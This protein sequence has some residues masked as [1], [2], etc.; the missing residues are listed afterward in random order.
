V[1]QWRQGG[2]T[3]DAPGRT[4]PRG[5]GEEE[6]DGSSSA[7]SDRRQRNSE[8]GAGGCSAEQS[9]ELVCAAQ[10]TPGKVAAAFGYTEWR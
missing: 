4:K 8:Q 10:C 2:A 6:A 1:P 7:M 3:D 9:K 5:T